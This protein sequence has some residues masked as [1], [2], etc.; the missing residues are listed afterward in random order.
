[1]EILEDH[2]TKFLS[3]IATTTCPVVVFAF[4][5]SY[6]IHPKMDHL[7][8]IYIKTLDG[9]EWLVPG[10]HHEGVSVCDDEFL[11]GL[12][13]ALDGVDAWTINKK[14]L[15]HLTSGAVSNI[16]DINLYQHSNG[17]SIITSHIKFPPRFKKLYRP[18]SHVPIYHIVSQARQ[19]ASNAFKVLREADPIKRD[20]SYSRHHSHV[21]MPFYTMERVGIHVD[22]DVFI[23]KYGKSKAHLID[24][25]SL[26][27]PSYDLYNTSTGRPSNAFG[28][29][30][31][32]AINKSDGTRKAYTSRFPNGTLASYDYDAFHLRLISKLIDGDPLAKL[33]YDT[34]VHEHFGTAY[35]FKTSS[36][37]T[38]DQYKESKKRSFSNLYGTVNPSVALS[39]FF[40]DVKTFK[41]RLWNAYQRYGHIQTPIFKRRISD[42]EDPST[43]K[44]FNYM[45]Q[46][47]ELEVMSIV[48]KRLQSTLDMDGVNLC[49]YTYD[50]L[51]F[52][53]SQERDTP[54]L[55]DT[56][57][58]VMEWNGI[59]VK[60]TKTQES[61]HDLG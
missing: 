4:P 60:C 31:Y 17:A 3:S 7:N 37:L 18:L 47:F 16:D 55:H 32:A 12:N 58:K 54:D 25:D 30:N 24:D 41:Q 27:Y 43:S 26:V 1:M 59:K 35:Y 51:L 13:V 21:L 52:D 48:M 20:S 9:H 61:Y 33:S 46:A 8:L 11:D 34:N 36:S 28:G 29:V 5:T 10:M 6:D 57:F 49:M 44:V 40:A 42:I 23:E 39:G 14:Q 50:S 45:L 19:M 22:R 2:T 56:I 53:I 38:P 15:L